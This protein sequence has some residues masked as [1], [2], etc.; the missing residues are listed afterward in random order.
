MTLFKYNSLK[1]AAWVLLSFR[2]LVTIVNHGNVLA[3]NK[4]HDTTTESL[5]IDGV[6][7]AF[8]YFFSCYAVLNFHRKNVLKTSF[9]VIGTVYILLSLAG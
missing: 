1:M 5:M 9:G 6:V 8:G 4:F 3:L 2:I 7:E